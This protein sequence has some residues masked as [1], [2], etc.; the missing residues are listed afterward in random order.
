MLVSAASALEVAIKKAMGR[1]RAPDDLPR[2]VASAGFEPRSIDFE[3]AQRLERLPRHHRDP[4][5]RMLVA[6]ALAE[7]AHL[8][9]RDAQLSAYGVPLLW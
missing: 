5:D 6:H 1:L 2:A 3:V 7:G 8:V 9:S 4:F